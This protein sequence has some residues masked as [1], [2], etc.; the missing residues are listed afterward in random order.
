M[1]NTKLLPTSARTGGSPHSGPNV[2]HN[3]C[4]WHQYSTLEPLACGTSSSPYEVLATAFS[5]CCFKSLADGEDAQRNLA[6]QM[7]L[8]LSPMLSMP[9]GLLCRAEARLH[10]LSLRP[11]LVI[12]RHADKATR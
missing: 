8:A 6:F 3:S 7:V 5:Q 1:E 2:G 11:R 4:L 9:N 10:C 12:L